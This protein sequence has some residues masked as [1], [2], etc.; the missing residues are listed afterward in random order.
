MKKSISILIFTVC[1]FN[2]IPH[3][4]M[5]NHPSNFVS[6]YS[7]G[8]SSYFGGDGSDSLGFFYADQNGNYHVFGSTTS[9]DLPVMRT[10][11]RAYCLYYMELLFPSCAHNRFVHFE[12]ETARKTA[13]NLFKTQQSVSSV[14]ECRALIRV[15]ALQQGLVVRPSK[16]DRTPKSC[17]RLHI[18]TQ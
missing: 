3:F 2:S 5:L 10:H 6:L 16:M 17:S 7:I 1:L 9:S 8:F 15:L 4:Q 13:E 12:G 11:A 14:C 18:S